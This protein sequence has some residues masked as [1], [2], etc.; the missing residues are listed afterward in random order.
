MSGEGEN[1]W[2]NQLQFERRGHSV[3]INKFIKLLIQVTLPFNFRTVTESQA[4]VHEHDPHNPVKQGFV[5]RLLERSSSPP[6]PKAGSILCKLF[7]TEFCWAC[8]WSCQPWRTAATGSDPSAS[9]QL[10]CSPS[11]CAGFPV[12]PLPVLLLGKASSALSASPPQLPS[13]LVP[14]ASS[15][16]PQLPSRNAEQTQIAP[17]NTI[18]GDVQREG[19]PEPRST[20]CLFSV[21][22]GGIKSFWDTGWTMPCFCWSKWGAL[23]SAPWPTGCSTLTVLCLGIPENKQRLCGGNFSCYLQCYR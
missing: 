3:K 21:C 18:W 10:P 9:T 6:V 12:S 5:G 4:C 7:W 14:A 1:T 2:S 16:P 19:R 17:R 23:Q 22:K 13:P 20:S 11:S 8:P 15:F